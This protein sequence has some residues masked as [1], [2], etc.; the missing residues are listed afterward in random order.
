MIDIIRPKIF[1]LS[2]LIMALTLVTVTSCAFEVHAQTD[3]NLKRRARPS[4]LIGI[5]SHRQAKA[6]RT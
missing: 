6:Y 1:S 3:A 2:L 4:S 5:G